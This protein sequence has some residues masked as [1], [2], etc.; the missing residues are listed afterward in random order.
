LFF[1]VTTCP[2]LV[3]PMAWLAKVN[4]T[5]VTAT[6][7]IPVPLRGIACELAPTEKFS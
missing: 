2:A 1:T 6:A 3:V 4:E 5:G 7:P